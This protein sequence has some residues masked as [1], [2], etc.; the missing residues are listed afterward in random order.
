MGQR[1][2]QLEDALSLLQASASSEPHPL[3]RDEFLKIKFPLEIS[4]ANRVEI[5]ALPTQEVDLT[6]ACG[7][8][9]LGEGGHTRY[10]GRTA[11]AE[12]LLG[13]EAESQHA[14]HFVPPDMARLSSFF[15]FIE[16][17]WDVQSCLSVIIG[18]LPDKPRAHY[19]CET[20]FTHALWF[21]NIV[22]RDELISGILVPVYAYK[23][24]FSSGNDL[25][26]AEDEA[27][28]TSPHRVAVLFFVLAIGTLVDLRIP[29][30]STKAQDYFDLGKACLSLKNLLGSPELE[31]VQALALASLYHNHGGPQYSAEATWTFMGLCARMAHTAFPVFEPDTSFEKRTL[32]SESPGWNLD[33]SMINRRRTIFWELFTNETFN[34]TQKSLHMGRPPA[35]SLIYSGCPFPDGSVDGTETEETK[36]IRWG[37]KFSKEVVSQ[38]AISTLTPKVPDY[39]TILDLDKK[40][41]EHGVLPH[42]EFDSPCLHTRGPTRLSATSCVIYSSVSLDLPAHC[43]A[44]TAS[45]YIHRSFFVKAIMDYPYDPMSSPYASS[46]LATFRDASTIIDLDVRAFFQDPSWLGRCWGVFGTLLAAGVIVGS[47]VTRC[48]S[49]NMT[50]KAFNDLKLTLDLFTRI[51]DSSGR[52]KAAHSILKRLHDKAT[53]MFGESHGQEAHG[54]SHET[55]DSGATLDDDLET[56]AGYTKFRMSNSRGKKDYRPEDRSSSSSSV[57]PQPSMGHGGGPGP[58]SS[59]APG[60]YSP[61]LPHATHD[62]DPFTLSLLSTTDPKPELGSIAQEL[63]DYH[64]VHTTH[65]HETDYRNHSHDK[66]KYYHAMDW[67]G[68]PPGGIAPSPTPALMPEGPGINA[69]WVAF[70]QEE[71]LPYGNLNTRTPRQSS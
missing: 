49:N 55:H 66:L 44:T 5:E 62:S 52:A 2:R 37:W 59:N 10:L 19:L 22:L 68:Q 8:L 41:R 42:A 39:A 11:G 16:G 7:T 17:P 53:R 50:H 28:P 60:I 67:G 14:N 43:R 25:S 40:I 18:H 29:P 54:G 9:T 1:I 64:Q 33:P 12:S 45:M 56:L 38:I 4:E 61:S 26:L 51:M 71:V 27:T 65:I 36:V 15:P 3:L 20:Y 34:I 31:T 35:L 58:S 32:D 63:Q 57:S 6:E 69:Q 13:G 47:I 48:P 70:M 21:M 23:E 46:F 24:S 30:Y